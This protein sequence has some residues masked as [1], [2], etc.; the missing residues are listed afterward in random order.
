MLMG[1]E[2]IDGDRQRTSGRRHA[3]AR[4]SRRPRSLGHDRRTGDTHRDA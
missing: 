3:L 4:L 1:V 2:R